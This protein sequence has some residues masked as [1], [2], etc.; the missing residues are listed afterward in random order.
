MPFIHP[1]YWL[2][3]LPTGLSPCFQLMTFIYRSMFAHLGRAGRKKEVNRLAMYQPFISCHGLCCAVVVIACC[4]E[5]FHVFFLFY[6]GWQ[7]NQ[8]VHQTAMLSLASK[9]L[10]IEV[11]WPDHIYIMKQHIGDIHLPIALIFA[12]YKLFVQCSQSQQRIRY[13]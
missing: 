13:C 1:F 2:L 6:Y 7:K 11:G 3:S 10:P 4:H 9:W 12:F 5:M 8:V